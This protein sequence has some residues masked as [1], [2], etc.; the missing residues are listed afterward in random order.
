MTISSTPAHL[1]IVRG[2]LERMCEMVGFDEI[3]R[4]GIVLA[5]DEALTNVIRH[6]YHGVEDKPIEITLRPVPAQ[7]GHVSLWIELRDW[8]DTA[9]PSK[10]RSRELDDVRP[11]G[12]GVYIMKRCM[13]QVQYAP[14]PGGGTFLTMIKTL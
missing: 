7:G 11:G 6:A 9:E 1:P 10:I 8:G 4:G 2:A 12:L 14:A 3:T 5:V 13:D